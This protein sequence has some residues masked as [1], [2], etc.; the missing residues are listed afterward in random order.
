MRQSALVVQSFGRENEYKRVMLTVLSFFAFNDAAYTKV[1]LFTDRPERFEK[2]FA[3]LDVHYVLLTGE[4]IQ[5][6][7]GQI[8]FLHRMKIALIEEAFSLIGDRFLFYAD[9]D[10][11][12]LQS[13]QSLLGQLDPETA[14]MHLKEYLF[15]A[16]ATFELPAGETFRAAHACFS[17][18]VLNDASGNALKVD[19][20]S[21]W[22][23]NAGVMCFH[24]KQ[25][26]II[27]DVY[28]LTDQI[29]PASGNHASEQY[30][31]SIML[32]RR[33]KMVPCFEYNYHYWYRT[34]KQIADWFLH[35]HIDAPFESLPLEDKISRAKGWVTRLRKE[36]RSN[37]RRVQD[38]AVQSFN[39]REFARGYAFAFKALLSSPGFNT[40]FYKD[41]L[42]HTKKMISGK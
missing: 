35:D 10:S 36:F 8:D 18:H 2:V 41:V 23:W 40:S 33:Y 20:K 37:I 30:A 4:K 39:R 6:M 29:Y 12:F 7:R 9:S 5:Q 16:M 27:P 25:A 21:E 24:P 13:I 15:E 31:F 38:E 22:S 1:I 26:E 34:K 19:P 11:F 42:Y 28:T 3:G 17:E 14:S 32:Q